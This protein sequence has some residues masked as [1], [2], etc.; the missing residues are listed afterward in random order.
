MISALDNPIR[1]GLAKQVDIQ[2]IL[3]QIDPLILMQKIANFRKLNISRMSNAEIDQAILDVLCWNGVFVCYTNIRK[4]PVGTKFFR[5]KRLKGTAI[6]NERFGKYRDYWET[7]PKYLTTYGR[8]NKPGESLLYTSP[9]IYCSIGEVHIQEGEPFVA[10]QYTAKSDI[11]VNMIGG[12]F[13]YAQLGIQDAK[14][15]LIHEIYNSFL[16]DEFSRDVGKGTE[17]LYRVSEEIAKSYFDLPPR[18]AQDAWAYSSV[19]D[20]T[21]YNV[22]FRPKIAHELLEL[23]GAMLCKMKPIGLQ[24]LCVAV[25]AD[26]NNNILF[27]HIG[28]EQQKRVFPE[29]TQNLPNK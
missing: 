18:I 16:R 8:L 22:C 25:G 17:Y 2:S 4:Y 10:I 13:D 14:V 27:Y 19:Q 29:I 15:K 3:S 1:P 21:K 6:P 7:D 20:K 9:D 12:E 24:V 5:I 26:E 23:N 11:K 28:S